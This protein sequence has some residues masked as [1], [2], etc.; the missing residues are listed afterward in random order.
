MTRRRWT[1]ADPSRAGRGW[2]WEDGKAGRVEWAQRGFLF[3]VALVALLVFLAADAQ[4]RLR[5][6]FEALHADRIAAL[7]A[8][9]ELAALDLAERRLDLVE[10]VALAAAQAQREGLDVLARRQVDL[11]RHLVRVE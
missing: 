4:R 6:R 9:A 8:G 11:V 5:P 1:E 3:E 7:F 10:E 2:R